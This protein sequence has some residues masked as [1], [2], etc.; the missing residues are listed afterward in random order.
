MLLNQ[1][2]LGSRLS[3]Q[4]QTIPTASLVKR[5]FTT[6]TRNQIQH[7]YQ[8]H[9]RHHYKLSFLHRR[10]SKLLAL[11][12]LPSQRRSFTNTNVTWRYNK[13]PKDFVSSSAFGRLMDKIPDSVKILIG[14]TAISSF[15]VFV[16]LPVVIMVVPPIIIG[17]YAFYKGRQWKYKKDSKR[18]WDMLADS[19]LIFKPKHTI[20]NRNPLFLPPPEQVN[21]ELATFELRR[22]VDAFFNNE[23][24]IADYFKVDDYNDLALGSIDGV[25]YTYNT[26]H[27]LTDLEGVMMVVQ[28]RKLYDR[29]TGKEI[30]TVSICLRNLDIPFFEDFSEPS[31]N[32]GRSVCVIEVTPNGLIPT[33]SFVIDSGSGFSDDDV[34]IDVKGR[35]RNL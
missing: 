30:A 32:I 29:N 9:P 21:N 13:P 15:V 22:I 23:N 4:Y 14:I 18:R 1:V 27:T 7:Q 25:Q 20:E 12:L 8:H 26:S 3:S 11:Q 5:T 31:A 33:K 24:G 6:F 2:G 10:S 19:N 35:T 17:G 28:S 34:I 16:A